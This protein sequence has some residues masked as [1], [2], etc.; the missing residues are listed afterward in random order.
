MDPI[1]EVF[2]NYLR[3]AIYNHAK[4]EL[5]L[6]KL[7]AGFHDFAKGLVYYT[8]CVQEVTDMVRDLAKGNLH[9]KAPSSDNETAA[10]LKSLCASLRHL[11]WQTQQ[12]AQ[13]DYCQRVNFMGEF[14]ASF[15]VMVEQLELR[16]R[17]LIEEI[18]RGNRKMMALAQSKN[19]F[20]AIAEQTT[21]WVIVIDRKEKIWRY[22]N[23]PSCEILVNTEHEDY[24]YEWLR[25]HVEETTTF[26]L[27]DELELHNGDEGQYFR[28]VIHPLHWQD[29]EALA[30]I[31]T[32]ISSGRAHIEKLEKMAYRD[33]LTKTYNRRYG[34]ELLADWLEK[35][36]GFT[37]CF[38]DM[39]NLKYVNDKF[40]HNE[41]DTY[42]LS[43]AEV[44]RQF[45]NSAIVS[46]LGGDEFMILA[47]G[48]NE[49][50]ACK[51]MEKLRDALSTRD[52]KSEREYNHSISYGL[53]EVNTDNQLTASELLSQ[54]DEKMYAYK[55]RR[56]TQSKL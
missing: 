56:K 10:P 8:G 26:P 39:D 32:D 42:I 41:G 22:V 29:Q 25:R 33:P 47:A 12:V 44:L 50:M 2:F 13:G 11:T 49:E 36:K 6:E 55:R 15:N 5:D 28:V 9:G 23:H 3:D 46:R 30:F 53:V 52:L 38:V 24:L 43:V 37:L 51:R 19:L 17:A 27:I 31:L 20:E 45:S 54:A 14:A 21:Q 40:G 16:Q 35:C 1:A 18:E 7:P 48:W 4:A 34:M